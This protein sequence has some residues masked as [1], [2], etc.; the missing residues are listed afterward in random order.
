[1]CSQ[2]ADEPIADDASAGRVGRLA[3]RAARHALSDARKRGDSRFCQD[4]RTALV[5]GT[6]RGA[7]DEWIE[8]PP[9]DAACSSSSFG[10]SSVCDDVARSIGHGMGPRLTMSGACASGLHALI[11]AAMLIQ[12]NDADRAIV[13]AAESSLHPM[14]LESFRRLGVLPKPG[15]RCRPFDRHRSGF[16]CAES[17]AAVVLERSEPSDDPRVRIDRFALAGDAGHLTNFD[18]SG[19]TLR[20]VLAKAVDNR[21]IDLIHAHGT[22]TPANDAAEAAAIDTVLAELPTTPGQA[23]RPNVYSHKGA[24]GH[25]VGAAGLVSIAL[26]VLMHRHGVV[27]PNVGV[28]TP[29]AITHATVARPSVHRSIRRSVATAAGFGGA[30]AAVS[31]RGSDEAT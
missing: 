16:L 31:L 28:E 8:P 1:M 7:A 18:P 27:P 26:N 21:P 4:D 14:F 9:T 13:V 23:V 11:R 19:A 5:V 3:I 6:S 29:I 15:E 25:T 12:Q 10:L 22:G 17:A 30:T 24:I 2:N 20:R